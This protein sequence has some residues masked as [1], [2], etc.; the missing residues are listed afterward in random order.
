MK[1]A[2]LILVVSMAVAM[3]GDIL[4]IDGKPVE[5]VKTGEY[6]P[7]AISDKLAKQAYADSLLPVR[8]SFEDG[9]V[10]WNAWAHEF[11]YAPYFEFKPVEGAVKYR[12]SLKCAD[13]A[14]LE[15]DA[16]SPHAAL[17]PVWGAVREGHTLVK[18]VGLDADGKELGVSGE[19]KFYRMLPFDNSYAPKAKPYMEAAKD[20]YRYLLSYD[21]IQHLKK[22]EPDPNYTR[23]CY[24]SKMHAAIINGL[25]EYAE[26]DPSVKAEA[27][28]I[29]SQSANFLIRTSIPAGQP[30]EYLPRTYLMPT[31]EAGKNLAAVPKLGTIMMIYPA[32][33]GS[34]MIHLYKETKNQAYLDY[35]VKIGEQYLR[36]Q[37]EDGTWALVYNID[38]G[39]VVA[40]NSCEPVDIL[41][42]LAELGDTTG[43]QAEF[44]K[45]AERGLGIVYSRIKSLDWEGQFEDVTAVEKPYNNLSKH[46]AASSF[47]F[48]ADVLK[49]KG[50]PAPPEF[51]AHARESLRF[52]EDQFVIWRQL[53]WRV[54]P[55]ALEQYRCYKNVDASLAKMI[56]FYL[57]LY[58]LEKQPLDLAKARA[59]GD[60]LTR[61]QMANGRIP[62]WCN[63]KNGPDSDWINC[64]FA[65]ANA[66]KLLAKYDEI[67]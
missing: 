39:A 7:E 14:E 58:D 4:Q 64:M 38:D 11:I 19:R 66:L 59:L 56:C 6:S 48:L 20:T 33:V 28:E 34:A 62:T 17:T 46:P 13:G 29:A 55:S 57:L 53:G 26:L 2:S 45:A 47:L 23:Y 25:L 5:I 49:Q 50:V 61:L 24:P 21:A 65:S 15:F 22:G 63:W 10:F 41:P 67:Q 52:A 44:R 3:G 31:T 54:A 9:Q 12:F 40:A 18:A 37:R 32:V 42:F 36:L 35:A 51:V 43:R 1:F 16:D 8:R 60:T 30:L 27:I